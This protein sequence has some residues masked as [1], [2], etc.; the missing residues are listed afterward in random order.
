MADIQLLHISRCTKAYAVTAPIMESKLITDLTIRTI[1]PGD[2]R[3]RISDGN[4]VYLLLFVKGGAHGWRL[5]YTF[6]GKRKTLSLGTYPDTSLAGARAKAQEARA[7]VASGIDPS[8]TRKELRKEAREAKIAAIDEELG[9]PKAGTFE[10]VA[11]KWFEVREDEWSKS[12]SSKVMRRLEVDIFP[13]LGKRDIHQIKPPDVLDAI[14][15]IEARGVVETAHRAL[16]SCFMIFRFA[17]AEGRMLLN[18]ALGLKDALKKPRVKHF[19]AIIDPD[20]LGQLLRAIDGYQG[21]PVVRAALQLQPMLLLRPGE[22]RFAQWDEISIEKAIWLVPGVRMK[23]EKAGKLNGGPHFVPLP[24]QAI[25]VFKSLQPFTG[26]GGY[27]FR[28]ER[29]HDRPMSENSVNAALR[30]LGFA[31]DEVVGHGFRATA[32]TMLAERLGIKEEIIEAQLA[33]SV[34]G[35]LGRTYNRTQF[36]DQ[37]KDML[38]RWAN[39][40]D[41]L[42]TQMP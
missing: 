20:R 26:S 19:P 18:P 36:A 30:A 2:P 9:L 5:D 14:R 7:S 29:H 33:H 32:R 23:R 42:R 17:I 38:Q 4:G 25:E 15:R 21:T 11:R 16:E 31:N 13:L 1:Q 3:R 39:Y 37:R 24:K 12:Y 41:A 35:S 40:L 28:G 8:D 22:L 27:V 10:D 6:G 34:K